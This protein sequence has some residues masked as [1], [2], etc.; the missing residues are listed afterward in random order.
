MKKEY[1]KHIDRI[2]VSV[3]FLED[4]A[5][6]PGDA[7][8]ADNRLILRSH[9]PLSGEM[10]RDLRRR[11]LRFIYYSP[12][13]GP[14]SEGCDGGIEQFRGWAHD[15]MGMIGHSMKSG[16]RPDMKKAESFIDD[17]KTFAL[18][19]TSSFLDLMKISDFDDYMYTHPVNVGVLS[20]I[21]AEK[22]GADERTVAE[23]G[24]GP[25]SRISGS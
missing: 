22:C 3:D 12:D 5:V 4:G 1:I 8:G 7:Y 24:L 13:S 14:S 16:L 15:L 10:I 21:L 18:A 20:M 17:L 25:Y 2:K 6:L 19:N 11:G 9:I 23:T